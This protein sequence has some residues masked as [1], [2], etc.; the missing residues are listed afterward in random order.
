M[1]FCLP[2]EENEVSSYYLFNILNNIKIIG[3]RKETN[4]VLL[5]YGCIT[6]LKVIS[7]WL[8]V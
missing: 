1:S 4:W 2:T 3:I 7:I 6:S 8:E 5:L